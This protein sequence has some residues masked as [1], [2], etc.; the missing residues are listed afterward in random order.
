MVIA[1][2]GGVRVEEFLPAVAGA[3]G[4]L[5]VV[6]AWLRLQLRRRER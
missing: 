6:R 1:H 3:G 2:V 4:V 5:L